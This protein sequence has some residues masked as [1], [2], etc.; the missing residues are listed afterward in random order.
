MF[1]AE[2]SRPKQLPPVGQ[3]RHSAAP[4]I[5]VLVEYEPIAKDKQKMMP[6][7]CFEQTIE[8]KRYMDCLPGEHEHMMPSLEVPY[9]GGHCKHAV[10]PASGAILFELHLSQ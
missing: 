2:V 6:L 3:A 9:G 10:L 8:E 5:S 1:A 7:R 4:L